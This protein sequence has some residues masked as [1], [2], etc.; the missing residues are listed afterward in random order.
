MILYGIYGWLPILELGTPTAFQFSRGDKVDS[1]AIE[2]ELNNMPQRPIG[3]KYAHEW[4]TEL[5]SKLYRVP[6]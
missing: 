1:W 2:Q 5:C 4:F 3:W 6:G